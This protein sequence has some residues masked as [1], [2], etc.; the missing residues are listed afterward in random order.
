LRNATLIYN[1]IAG[2]EP[3]RRAEQIRRIAD[4][5]RVR[6]IAAKPTPTTR[7]GTATDL[8]R[9]AVEAGDDLILVCGGDGTLNEVINGM[10]PANVPLAILPGGTANIA[11]KELRLPRDPL[12]AACELVNWSPRRLALGLATGPSGARRYFFSVAGVGFDAYVIHRLS[13]SFKMSAGVAAYVLEALRQVW[14]YS[15]PRFRCGIDGTPRHAT[16]AV[17]HR[18]S[19]Y[20]GWL[21]MAPGA[22]LFEPRLS[23]CLFKSAHRLRHFAYAAA[24]LARQHLRL[25][26]VELV[27]TRK[28]ECAASESGARIYFELDGELAGELPA[29]FEVVPDALTV[30][31][32]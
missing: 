13:S 10:A 14:R 11:A 30:L 4:A 32:P 17:V 20:A 9:A 19:R 26:D 25:S 18:T 24:V 22:S 15:F 2:R 27:E 16:L 6:S 8:A 21:R 1:P 31:V 7:G 12:R 28:V 29:S 3:S 5:L 23:V